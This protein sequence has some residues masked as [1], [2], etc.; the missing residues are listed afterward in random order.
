MSFCFSRVRDRFTSSIRSC[1][2]LSKYPLTLRHTVYSIIPFVSHD[3]RHWIRFYHFFLKGF[4][5]YCFDTGF[6]VIPNRL[7]S[8]SSV[9]SYK[10]GFRVSPLRLV[11][12][13]LFVR[14]QLSRPLLLTVTVLLPFGSALI[15]SVRF[16]SMSKL[17]P[18]RI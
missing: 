10:V 5:H 16:P 17:H 14:P 1:P 2:C 11:L 13:P 15:H 12:R 4:P 3:T 8:P 18:T 7:L 9:P 6:F